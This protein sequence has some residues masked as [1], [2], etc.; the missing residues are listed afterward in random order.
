MPQARLEDCLLY[1]GE[2]GRGSPLLLLQGLGGSHRSWGEPFLDALAAHFR[3]LTFDHRGTGRSTRGTAPYTIP[4]LAAD[5]SRALTS[6]GVDRA[7]V[8]GLSMGGMV[9]QELALGFSERVGGLVLASTNCGGRQS[10]WPSPAGRR[11]FAESI[12]VGESAWP[13]VVSSE[14][15]GAQPEFVRRVAMETVIAGAAPSVLVEQARAVSRFSTF[16]RL[17]LILSPTLVM[18]GDKDLLIPPENG[19][20]LVRRIRDAQGVVVRGS[21]HVFVWEAPERA[22]A[23][24]VR[25]LEGPAARTLSAESMAR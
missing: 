25:F 23:E 7:H 24:V 15:A 12:G 4:Q 21:G 10:I 18:V 16:D 9:A 3:V 19:R 6:L 22:A 1:C 20:V 14:F 17:P 2:R 5:A 11:R 13:L 8:F